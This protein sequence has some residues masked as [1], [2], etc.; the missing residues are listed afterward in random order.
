MLM[1]RKVELKELPPSLRTFIR[2]YPKVWGAHERLGLECLKAGPLDDKQIQLTKIAITASLM[3]ETSFK[4]HVRK[5]LR[6]KATKAEI[7]HTIIQLLPIVG[8]GRTM[9]ALKWYNEAASRP[10]KAR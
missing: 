4:T 1:Q 2:R 7:E 9:M 5:A 3:L 10:R 8:I 6:A